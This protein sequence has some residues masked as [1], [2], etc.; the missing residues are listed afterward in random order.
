M[1]QKLK[2]EGKSAPKFLLLFYLSK[3]YLSDKL[4]AHKNIP[5]YYYDCGSDYEQ[6]YKSVNQASYKPATKRGIFRAFRE[7]LRPFILRRQLFR[8]ITRSDDLKKYPKRGS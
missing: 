1:G 8:I 5:S 4:L 7:V 3:S 2:D 6:G